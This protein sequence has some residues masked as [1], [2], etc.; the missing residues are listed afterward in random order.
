MR[1]AMKMRKANV[2]TPTPPIIARRT[3]PRLRRLD[4]RAL[5][6]TVL[7]YTRAWVRCP[8]ATGGSVKKRLSGGKIFLVK[9]ISCERFL[10]RFVKT[11][12]R[13]RGAHGDVADAQR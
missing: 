4:R 6:F 2:T 12:S 8:D 9:S 11:R 7:G 3:V 5:T 1:V 10:N 13:R